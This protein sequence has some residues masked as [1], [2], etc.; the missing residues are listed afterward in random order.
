MR[1]EVLM[2]LLISQPT[3][4]HLKVT[5]TPENFHEGVVYTVRWSNDPVDRQML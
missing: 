5:L 3:A 1:V 2:G 4:V